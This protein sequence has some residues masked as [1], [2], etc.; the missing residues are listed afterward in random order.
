MVRFC[1]LTIQTNCWSRCRKMAK[2][3][4]IIVAP[5]KTTFKSSRKRRTLG[6]R[7][8]ARRTRD[9]CGPEKTERVVG[10]SK[11][12]S[13]EDHLKQKTFNSKR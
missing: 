7:T 13:V 4:A 8:G 10:S 9:D 6:R 1:S 11:R 3:R 5:G 2:P 12:K